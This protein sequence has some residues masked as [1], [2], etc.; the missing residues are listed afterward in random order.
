MALYYCK[1]KKNNIKSGPVTTISTAFILGAKHVNALIF[2]K[3]HYKFR[4]IHC[5]EEKNTD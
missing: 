1:K 2:I 4:P 3:M 5:I